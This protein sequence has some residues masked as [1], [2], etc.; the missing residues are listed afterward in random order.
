MA[1]P[2]VLGASHAHRVAGLWTVLSV[3]AAATTLP[4]H[5]YPEV[6]NLPDVAPIPLA[7]MQHLW[8]GGR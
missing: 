1:Q 3:G 2:R 7:V 4:P 8:G 6:A 5:T